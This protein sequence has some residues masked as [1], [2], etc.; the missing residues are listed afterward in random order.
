M[1]QIFAITSA[2]HSR[3]TTDILPRMGQLVRR[4]TQGPAAVWHAP[5]LSAGLGALLDHEFG[6][7]EERNGLALALD[8]RIS[9]P[10]V[11]SS[12][13][14]REIL[15]RY[16]A[17]GP[18]FIKKLRGTF[19]LIIWDSEL[20][21]M[22]CATDRVATRSL[23]WLAQPGLFA[24]SSELKALLAIPGAKVE[25]DPEA[26]A[27]YLRYGHLFG[28]RTIWKGVSRLGPATVVQYD[29]ATEQVSQ[30]QYWSA[31][32]PVRQRHDLTPERM[33][34]MRA[35]FRSS[36][37]E[38]CP[39][40]GR[41][42]LSLS[43]GLD[44]RGILA[45][46]AAEKRPVSLRTEGVSG[47]VDEK[48]AARLAQS[49]GF[50]WRF[51]PLQTFDISQYVEAMRRYVYLTEGM[52]VPEGYPGVS[53]VRFATEE[54][55]SVLQRGHG[56]ENARVGDAWPYQVRDEVLGLQTPGDLV[57]YLEPQDG[58]ASAFHSALFADQAIRRSIAEPA[59]S[60]AQFIARYSRDLTPAEI[61]SLM[62]LHINEGCSVPAFRNCLRGYT[63]MA[64]PYAGDD[65]LELVLETKITHRR[66]STIHHD[67]IRHHFPGLMKIANSN[68]GAP[69]DASRLRLYVTD[70][71]QS[72]MRRIS[73]PGFRHYHNVESWIRTK[74][75]ESVRQLLM[76]SRTRQRGLFDPKALKQV[77]DDTG[78]PG[79]SR[80][81]ARLVMIEMW[82]R[83][84]VDREVEKY[85]FD[86]EIAAHS[87]QNGAR[88]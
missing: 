2:K 26:V 72:L 31:D 4:P 44:S 24:A 37:L 12:Q 34:Q 61:M 49:T 14:A 67:L 54:G 69:L 36:V 13:I 76:E 83:M 53:A 19:A 29:I 71:F 85:E 47:C 28:T 82:L 40:Q 60:Y 16:R 33:E 38:G 5:D 57:R 68:N 8:G 55:L 39:R 80:L 45:V 75:R 22:I 43:G 58:G 17:D 9:V 32:E 50:P 41:V 48:V 64:V 66:D 11:E 35:A 88:G 1:A 59:G 73:L 3:E 30:E 23:Y 42:G 84:F 20:R 52:M 70:K 86:L 25:I 87:A 74:V 63:D 6:V 15:T 27:T 62:Y 46:L 81:L 79:N 10:R 51:N 78:R 21:G 65:F 77:L 56:G 18:E 7:L